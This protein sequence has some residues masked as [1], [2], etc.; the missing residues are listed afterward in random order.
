M[1]SPKI[2]RDSKWAVPSNSRRLVCKFG[3]HARGTTLLRLIYV[4]VLA[5]ASVVS[6]P[7]SGALAASA[8]AAP[9]G[10][11]MWAWGAHNYRITWLDNASDES[12]FQITN[13]NVTITTGP[14]PGQ[15]STGVWDW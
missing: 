11:H 9:S 14:V 1:H 13:G 15:G 3:T 2:S 8:P 6:G 5:L 4:F 12:G 7:A 10:L